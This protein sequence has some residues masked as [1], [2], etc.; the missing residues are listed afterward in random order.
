MLYLLIIFAI[1]FFLFYLSSSTSLEHW[2]NYN[3]RN[4]YHNFFG[5]FPFVVRSPYNTYNTYRGT[6]IH[7]IPHYNTFHDPSQSYVDHYAY[8]HHLS[9]IPLTAYM[10]RIGIISKPPLTQTYLL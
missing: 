8:H 6:G 3:F 9:N 10:D 5:N 2:H 4:S 7:S 1:I